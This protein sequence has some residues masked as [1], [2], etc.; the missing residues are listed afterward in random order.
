M[1]DHSS[2]PTEADVAVRSGIALLVFMMVHGALFG[3][4]T[5]LAPATPL[6]EIAMRMM[7]WGVAQ[8][9]G[10]EAITARVPASRRGG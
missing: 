6:K 5:V 1:H 10:A 2:N 4:G 3:A 8:T 9:E 7:P